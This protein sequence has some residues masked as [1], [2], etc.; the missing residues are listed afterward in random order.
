MV[1][2]LA[3]FCVVDCIDYAVGYTF[4]LSSP[5]LE[6][7]HHVCHNVP[8]HRTY[9]SGLHFLKQKCSCFISQVPKMKGQAQ[10][11]CCVSL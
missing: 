4:H 5:E 9:C 10:F 6:G 11:C 1:G 8:S 7:T 2:N 3:G